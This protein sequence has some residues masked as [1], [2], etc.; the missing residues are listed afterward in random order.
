MLGSETDLRTKLAEEIPV[1]THLGVSIVA[2]DGGGLT[3]AAPL[4]QNRNHEGTG[5]AG[6]VSTL[7]TLA[8]WGL[9]WLRLR[10]EK[11]DC[12]VVIQDATVEYRRPVTG[13]FQARAAV[14]DEDQWR[15]LR[16]ALA[17]RGRGR[18]TV[19]VEVAV[20]GEPVA[21]FRGR[22]VALRRRSEAAGPR[23]RK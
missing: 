1:T 19:S 21:A 4:S 3:L 12:Q 23:G 17:K 16:E 2:Y 11:V 7:A 8:G 20:A 18:V 9:V 6:S 13:D 5:F 10:S 14:P 22:Y 15:R